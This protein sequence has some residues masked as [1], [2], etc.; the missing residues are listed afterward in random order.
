MAQKSPKNS[1]NARSGPLGASGGAIPTD[2]AIFDPIIG[3]LTKKLFIGRT[4]YPSGQFL[5]V[6]DYR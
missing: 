2:F 3:F 4:S 5:H 1:E 6:F